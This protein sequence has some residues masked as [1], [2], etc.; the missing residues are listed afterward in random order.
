VINK[1]IKDS[2][3]P[4][5]FSEKSLKSA[6]ELIDNRISENEE[7]SFFTSATLSHLKKEVDS[8]LT[9]GYNISKAGILVPTG[10]WGL[11]HGFSFPDADIS[12]LGIGNHRFFL[13]HSS[14]GLIVL[15]YFYNQWVQKLD[16]EKFSNRA[17]KKISGMVLGSFS[18]GVGI[19]LA[20]DVFQP[21]SIV[22]PFFGS[23]VDG[24]LVDDNIWLMGNS[25]WAF[26]IGKD[27][28]TLTLADEIEMAKKYVKEKFGASLNYNQLEKLR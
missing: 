23:L 18:I 8:I 12:L 1:I 26:K 22:F 20:V 5:R 7:S 6:Y 19:H 11:S 17:T 25:L 24:T 9:S 3:M 2:S 21:K 15:R 4:E 10:I 16:D 27:I 14:I 13:F 28:F